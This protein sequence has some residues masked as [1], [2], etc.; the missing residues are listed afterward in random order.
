M[1]AAARKEPVEPAL[2]ARSA[3]ELL[4]GL[5]A[6]EAGELEV[7]DL[8]GLRAHLAQVIADLTPTPQRGMSRAEMWR[9][10]AS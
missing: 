9:L 7:E 8:M 2:T 3:M 6:A 5:E 10:L 4:R 1:E